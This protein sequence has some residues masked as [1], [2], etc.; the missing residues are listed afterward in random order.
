PYQDLALLYA[1]LGDSAGV[2]RVHA[3]PAA[4][5]PAG[6]W[7]VTDS[8]EW[9]AIDA[10]AERRWRAAA[11]AFSTAYA[12]LPCRP[13]NAFY[14][15]QM[16]DAANVPDSAVAYYERGIERRGMYFDDVEDAMLYPV[17]LR[18]LG[19]LYEAR[20]DRTRALEYYQKFLDLWRTADPDLKPIVRDVEERVSRLTAEPRAAL[21]RR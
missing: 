12:K 1:V 4:F 10:W 14:A 16:W 2:R 11:I 3:S 18:R 13:C 19:D 6:L 20:G 21:Q 17:A 9:A 15:A 8:L 7:P 5:R